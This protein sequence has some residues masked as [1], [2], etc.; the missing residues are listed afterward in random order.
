[1]KTHCVVGKKQKQIQRILEIKNAARMG[2][3]FIAK[4]QFFFF[5]VNHVLL[6]TIFFL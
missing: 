1:M 6:Y 2:G 3:V 5:D 4:V